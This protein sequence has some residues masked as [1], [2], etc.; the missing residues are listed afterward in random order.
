MEELFKQL[1]TPAIITVFTAL[2]SGIYAYFQ[3]KK[4]VYR[5]YVYE[6]KQEDFKKLIVYAEEIAELSPESS[7]K[8]KKLL[9]KISQRINPYGRRIKTFGLYQWV[10]DD[11]YIWFKIDDIGKKIKEGSVEPEDL[12]ELAH[13]IQVSKRL[14]DVKIEKDTS[15]IS[16]SQLWLYFLQYSMLLLQFLLGYFLFQQWSNT[17]DEYLITSILF[18]SYCLLVSIVSLLLLPELVVGS[19]NSDR[20]TPILYSILISVIDALV[21]RVICKDIIGVERSNFLGVVSF[22]YFCL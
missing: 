4:E 1:L 6:N 3:K 9:F 21:V 5:K 13:R 12:E 15:S 22:F 20:K 7:E 11:G 18:L 16:S 14:L 19:G 17:K 8:I 10:R 2:I